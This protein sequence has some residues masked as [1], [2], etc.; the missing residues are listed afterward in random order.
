MP[1]FPFRTLTLEN[2]Q[3][4]FMFSWWFQRLLKWNICK[5]YIKNAKYVLPYWRKENS[6]TLKLKR[7]STK[8]TFTGEAKWTQTGLRFQSAMKTSSVHVT[9][10]FCCISKRPDILMDMCRHFISVSVYMIISSPEMKFH[11]CQNDRYEIHT[12][13]EFQTHMRIKHNFLRVCVYSFR[14][15]SVHMK[16]SCRF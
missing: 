3:K 8:S 7:K 15:N 16:I 12:R 1:I 9:C 2:H 11:F 4:R 6:E 10:H 5:K 13:N 14:V